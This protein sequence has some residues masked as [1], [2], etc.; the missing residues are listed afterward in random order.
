M[1][2]RTVR[3]SLAALGPHV[4]FS[5]PAPTRVLID[6]RC[7]YDLSLLDAFLHPQVGLDVFFG[8]SLICLDKVL[9]YVRV[10]VRE[11]DAGRLGGGRWVATRV[12]KKRI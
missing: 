4:L 12:L 6:N 1:R 10:G 9:K 5:R 2:L 8:L 11:D 3:T 7:I